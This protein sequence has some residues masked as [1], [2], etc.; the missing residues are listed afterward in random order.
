MLQ[1][2]SFT[3]NP[4][5]ENTYVLYDETGEALI[6][7]PGCY[8]KQEKGELF[9]FIASNGLEPVK[10]VN[11]HCHIDHVLGNAFIKN[12]YDIPLWYHKEEEVILRAVGSYAPNYGF[13][14]YQ[15]SKADHYIKEGEWIKFG[16]NK[17]LC[18]WVPGHSP[19]HLVFYDEHTKSCIGGD[20]LF[21]G[22]IGRTDLPGGHHETLI[23]AIKT[24]LFVLPDEVTV[25]PGHGPET[26]IGEE[27]KTNP[28]V[29]E[30]ITH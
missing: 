5:A 16:N 7:D 11:T 20:A 13:A 12:T 19:G 23:Q 15:D 8:E 22:S 10:L 4:F 28:F 17:L 27:K 3:F 29:G 21:K 9:D 30:N 1:I 24:K 2:K 18:I 6:I 14:Q 26:S 25:Y